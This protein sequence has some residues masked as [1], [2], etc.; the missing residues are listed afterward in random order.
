MK[1][2]GNL[3]SRMAFVMCF[4]LISFAKTAAGQE[5]RPDTCRNTIYAEL[6]GPG[7]LYSI[8]YDYLITPKV[9]IRAGFSKWSLPVVFFLMNGG[10]LDFTGFPVALNYLAG[11]GNSRLEFGAGVVPMFL[12]VEGEGIFGGRIRGKATLFSETAAVGYRY[13]P[14]DGG[15]VFRIGF[16]PLFINFNKVHA[17]IL[18]GGLSFGAAF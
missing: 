14:I 4:L 5:S 16:T 12:S 3:A 17:V 11:E 2:I 8:N 1:M 10:P 6:L 9:S 15:F 18:T 13:Q 7:I